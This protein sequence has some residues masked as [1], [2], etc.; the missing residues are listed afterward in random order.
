MAMELKSIAPP[1][2]TVSQQLLNRLAILAERAAEVDQLLA[3]RLTPY[4]R[5]ADQPPNHDPTRERYPL[6][7]EAIAENLDRIESSFRS[8][9]ITLDSCEL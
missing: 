2:I 3:S 1:P 9:N 6:Y 7:F 8:I 5:L 4:C